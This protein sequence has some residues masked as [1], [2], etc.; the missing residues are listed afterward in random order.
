MLVVNKLLN[1]ALYSHDAAVWRLSIRAGFSEL[2]VSFVP[3]V[4]PILKIIRRNTKA[5]VIDKLP[6]V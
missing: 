4:M 1:V 5:T 6:K 3:L 2:R